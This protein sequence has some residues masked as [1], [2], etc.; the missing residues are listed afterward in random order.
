MKL[1]HPDESNPLLMPELV[2]VALSAAS[3][4]LLTAVV[5]V[6]HWLA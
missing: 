1:E 5:G 2:S 6:I 3:L 4:S